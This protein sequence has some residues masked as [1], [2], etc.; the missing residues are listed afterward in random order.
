MGI[1][2]ALQKLTHMDQTI[3]EKKSKIIRNWK[4]DNFAKTHIVPS[5]LLRAADETKKTGLLIEFIAQKQKS[6]AIV[7]EHYKSRKDNLL[8]KGGQAEHSQVFTS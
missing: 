4:N 8:I 5:L 7:L 1:F 3:Q 6:F 2:P